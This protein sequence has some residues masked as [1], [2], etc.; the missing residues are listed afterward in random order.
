MKDLSAFPISRS[1]LLTKLISG[2]VVL[3]VKGTMQAVFNQTGMFTDH[4][5]NLCTVDRCMRQR[6]LICLLKT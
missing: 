2:F 3:K 6:I 4:H 5:Q 1:S